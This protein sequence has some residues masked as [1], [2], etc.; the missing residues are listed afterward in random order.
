MAV[1][2]LESVHA[3]H[4]WMLYEKD[5]GFGIAQFRDVD[6]DKTF[7]ALGYGLPMKKSLL[8]TMYGEWRINPK[9]GKKQFAM[10]YYEIPKQTEESGIVAYL[11]SLRCG[12]GTVKANMITKHFGLEAWDI[13]MNHPWRLVEVKGI[14][15]S[16][17]EKIVEASKKTMGLKEVVLIFTR[18]NARITPQQANAFLAAHKEDPVGDLTKNPYC[19]CKID[20][21]TFDKADA[22]ADALGF[23]MDHPERVKAFVTKALGDASV[24]GHVCLP[25]DQLMDIMTDRLGVS[26]EQ[27]R[28]ALNAVW[29]EGFIKTTNGMVYTARSYKEETTI[30]IEAT[31]LLKTAMDPITRID[32]LIDEYEQSNF[33]LAESQRNAVKTVFNTPLSI[34]TG[35]PGTGKTTV[36]KAILTVHKAIYGTESHPVLLAPTGRAARRMTDA[37]GYPAQTIHSAVGYRGVEV[38]SDEDAEL[39]GNLIIVDECSMMDQY[40][41]SVLLSKCKSGTR[42][43]LVG[44]PDQLPSVGCGNVLL[45]MIASKVIPTT[46]LTVIFRQA[47]E[48][49]IVAN[50]HAINEGK[51]ELLWNKT[52]KE[53]VCAGNEEMFNTAVDFYIRCVNA[54]GMDNVVLLNPQ[55]NNTAI[56]VGEFNR[57]LQGK[58]NPHKDGVPEVNIGHLVFRKGDKVMQLKNTEVAKNGDVG[59]VRDIRTVPSP[60]D[61]DT[62]TSE[63][64]I[65]FNGDGI[66]HSY[67]MDDMRA[68]DL[69]YCSTVHKS[70]GEEYATVI[71]VVSKAHPSML[72]RNLVYTGITRAKQ[73]V[74]IITEATGP[75]EP[76]ALDIAIRNNSCDQRYT[77]LIPRLRVSMNNA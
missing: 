25:A 30:A 4:T 77:N 24:Q 28:D 40:I 72:R 26:R 73:N 9:D 76:S 70:Q 66:T 32:P 46:K 29:Q 51:T 54:Y 44:D 34:I 49:P 61:P 12:I 15:A 2:Q 8:V 47:G 16:L 35:G 62:T 39:D 6:T 18:A 36:V 75:R 33:K 42:V 7:V 23:P 31:R 21:I 13:I 65:E 37:T 22:V 53:K 38:S 58:L 1:K 5:D 69:A 59:Y 11:T 52:F 55:R 60:D 17:T 14:G 43:V 56:S 71:M 64:D 27:C 63:V 48:N 20:G 41:A 19:A 67:N 50:A 74:C 57:V 10:D 3:V 68:V 45:D